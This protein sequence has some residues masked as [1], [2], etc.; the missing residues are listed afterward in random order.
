VAPVEPAVPA[1]LARLF[2]PPRLSGGRWHGSVYAA[3]LTYNRKETLGLC[4][5]SLRAQTERPDRVLIIDN[6]S[7]DGTP[8]FLAESG[9]L[10]DPLFRLVRLPRNIGAARGYERM[11]AVAY[12]AGCDW[13]WF[14]DDDVV[15]APDALAELK[16][17]FADHFAR[18]EDV[19]FLISSA[20]TPDGKA[21]DV[22]PV[23]ERRPVNA[24]AGWADYLASGLVKVRSSALNA[25]L[26]PRSTLATFGAP[27]PDFEIWGE[28]SDYCLRVT[29]VL[30]SFIVGRSRIVHLRGVPGDLDILTEPASPRLER[31]YYLYRNTMYLRRR[32]W[33]RYA[34]YLF[35]GKVVLHTFRCLGQR[36]QP[37]RRAGL[38]LRGALAGLFFTPHYRSLEVVVSRDDTDG[39]RESA[40]RGRAAPAA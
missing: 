17:A 11:F 35:I 21:N 16:R 28:D 6:G 19:G 27:C 9:F 1:E 2:P 15:A 36:E 5:A 38:V 10:H 7:T 13:V 40:A 29:S 34:Y 3:V 32:F 26:I 18:P 4:L 22:P 20:V 14:M 12:E 31:F 39:P 37:I 30:P 24:S 23:D 33:P 25:I 8:E